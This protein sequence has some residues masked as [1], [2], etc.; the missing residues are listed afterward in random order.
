LLVHLDR[1]DAAV[2]PL[3]LV[4]DDR[5]LK[6]GV[7]LRE[8]MLEDVG[9]AEQD[10]RAQATQLEP[11]DEAFEIDAAGRILG[12]MDHQVALLVDREVALAPARD[13]VELG[14]LGG[15]P[16]RSNIRP[17]PSD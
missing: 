14:R 3:V 10:R 16:L 12:G 4:L 11:I 2:P 7:D 6:G 5:A 17:E 1:V 8:T 9:E 13:V 15:C